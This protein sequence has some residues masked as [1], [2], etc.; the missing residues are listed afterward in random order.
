M[1]K[2]KKTCDHIWRPEGLTY[3]HWHMKGWGTMKHHVCM[4]CSKIEF[5]DFLPGLPDENETVE[6][7]FSSY[8]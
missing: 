2:P 6:K 5:Y 4:I 7:H 8:E 1:K 3:S